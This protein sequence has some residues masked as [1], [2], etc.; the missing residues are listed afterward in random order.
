MINIVIRMVRRPLGRLILSFLAAGTISLGVAPAPGTPEHRSSSAPDEKVDYHRV[1]IMLRTTAEGASLRFD[2]T[3]W[4]LTASR[5]ALNGPVLKKGL[6]LRELWVAPDSPGHSVSILAHYALKP[7]AAG[8]SL[9]CLLRQL[10]RGTS[11]LRVS[12]YENRQYVLLQEEH[13]ESAGS[14]QVKLDFSQ[15]KDQGVLSGRVFRVSEQKKIWAF[16]YPW[17]T[18]RWDTGI[19]SDKPGVGYYSSADPKII[20]Y[21]VEKALWSKI[22]GFISSWWGPGDYTDMNLKALLDIAKT[23]SFRV[24]INFETLTQDSRGQT[25]PLDPDTIVTWLSYAISRY[26]EHPAYLNIEGKPVIVLWA[27]NSLPVSTWETIFADL[28]AKGKE[29]H[30]IAMSYGS[31]PPLDSLDKAAGWH[32]YNIL[33]VIQKEEEVPTVLAQVYLRNKRCVRFYPLFASPPSPRIWCA[34]AQP[35]YDDHLIPGR[36]TPILKRKNGDLYKQTLQAALDS[37]PD[38]IFITSWNEWWEHTYI[39]PS[40]KYGSLYLQI[41]KQ[42]AEQWKSAEKAMRTSTGF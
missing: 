5:K 2:N 21:H 9:S 28:K 3:G 11:L 10:G 41:T 42:Y 23:K 20:K 40:K 25:V 16:Y 4:L 34:T 8:Q 29:G 36:T 13:L 22:D 1:R 17:Y 15:L 26:A 19:L 6:T 33:Q 37:D 24:M 31:W 12:K 27:S 39:E 30:F 35:G 7:E 38:W 32:Y 14:K 18:D